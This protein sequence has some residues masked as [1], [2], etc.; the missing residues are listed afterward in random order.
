MRYQ[1]SSSASFPEVAR[2]FGKTGRAETA[3]D[4]APAGH[5]RDHRQLEPEDRVAPGHDATSGW[6]RAGPRGADPG[7]TNAWTCRSRAASTCWPPAS[8][9][10][11]GSRSSGPISIRSRRWASGSRTCPTV[12]GT[13]ARSPSARCRDTTWTSTSERLA[14]A[15]YGL[16]AADIH[17]A[18]MATV[19]GMDVGSHRG[20]P[21]ALP[22]QRPLPP[23]APR[24]RPEAPRSADPTAM[25]GRPDSAWRGRRPSTSSRGR[26]R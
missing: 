2:V 12:P 1:D 23:R 16:T 15:R 13:G 9:R 4:P 3:T 11:S 22:G 17:R 7:V 26:W 19:G 8:G 21:G 5:V 6:W 25:G 18:I 14:A 10:R 20:G 24:R